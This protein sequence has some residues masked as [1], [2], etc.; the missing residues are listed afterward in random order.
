MAAMFRLGMLCA[1]LALLTGC[2]TMAG[3][4]PERIPI[5]SVPAGADVVVKCHMGVVGTGVTP[6]AILVPRAA[7]ECVVTISKEGY[8]PHA[9]ALESGMN[10]RFWGNLPLTFG[11]PIALGY[12]VFQPGDSQGT[13]VAV[14]GLGVI[15]AAGMIVDSV[16][17]AKRDHDPK[18]ISVTLAPSPPPP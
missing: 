15:G 1:A 12:L 9:V 16:T 4:G 6:T 18:E 7:E 8:A 3:S 10:P 2:A 13:A 11:A 17:D 5:E 14:L